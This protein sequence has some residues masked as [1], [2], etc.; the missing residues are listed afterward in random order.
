MLNT[1]FLERTIEGKRVGQVVQM[2]L[3]K[4]PKTKPWPPEVK[5][6]VKAYRETVKRL[7]SHEKGA[8]RMW[9]RVLGTALL[10]PEA[11]GGGDVSSMNEY[12]Y[13]KGLIEEIC[14]RCEM[15]GVGI[16]IKGLVGRE[17]DQPER[18]LKPLRSLYAQ[19]YEQARFVC[20]VA[21]A[22]GNN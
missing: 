10:N 16:V 3:P 2:E 19:K 1:V 15:F 13:I 21:C 22:G 6:L 20:C 8:I 14:C 17:S 7:S 5:A 12:D 9:V 4:Q 11:R 18:L